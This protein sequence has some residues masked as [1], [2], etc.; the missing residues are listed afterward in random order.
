MESTLKDFSGYMSHVCRCDYGY[1]EI[2][3]AEGAD[4]QRSILY[5]GQCGNRGPR[6]KG[7]FCKLLPYKTG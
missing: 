2:L 7:L 4:T 1:S 6:R 5:S 3:I